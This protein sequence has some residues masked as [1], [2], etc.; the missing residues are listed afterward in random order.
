MMSITHKGYNNDGPESMLPYFPGYKYEFGKSTYRGETVGEGGY[1]YAE[2][3]I[4]YNVA[5]QCFK[6]LHSLYSF[7]CFNRIFFRAKC[8]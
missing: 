2:P 6:I 4:Y 7:N 8:R 3:G 1:V 5:L